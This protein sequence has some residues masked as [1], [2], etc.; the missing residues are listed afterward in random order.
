M[1]FTTTLVTAALAATVS[2]APQKTV[3]S[4]N[5]NGSI[6][7]F[8]DAKQCHHIL[9]DSGACGISTY[10]K[11]VNQE[12]SFVAM[13]SDVFDKYGSAQNNKLCGKE[14][15]I[16]HN[17]QTRKAIVADRNLSND[18]SIDMCLD[19]WKAFGGKDNDGTVIHGMHFSINI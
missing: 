3:S 14:I 10:F 2:A 9:R 15:T 4:N 8:G 19:L 17:G 5:Q 12:A 16:S 13:P 1:Q 11:K 6:Y 18:H 7:R